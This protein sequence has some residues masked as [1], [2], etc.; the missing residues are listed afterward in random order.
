MPKK[1]E[2]TKTTNG[3]SPDGKAFD[4]NEDPPKMDET[5]YAT[6]VKGKAFQVNET[7]T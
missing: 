3:K 1:S 7:N 2:T 6:P 5:A 4:V